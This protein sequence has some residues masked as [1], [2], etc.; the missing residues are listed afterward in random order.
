MLRSITA[1]GERFGCG[2][3]CTA[4]S[5]L[6]LVALLMQQGDGVG[7]ARALEGKALMV[8]QELDQN[9]DERIDVTEFKN[10]KTRIFF[11][12]NDKDDKPGLSFEETLVTRAQFDAADADGDGSLSSLEWITAP[13]TDFATFDS[14]SDQSISVEEFE[15]FAKGVLR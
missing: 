12:Q 3:V 8:F 15:A 7:V 11:M 10:R 9:G 6:A 5:G 2:R 14:N 4:V 1:F 13:F